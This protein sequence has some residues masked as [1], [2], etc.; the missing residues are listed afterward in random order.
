MRDIETRVRHESPNVCR[1]EARDIHAA[2]S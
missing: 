1:G 2:Q